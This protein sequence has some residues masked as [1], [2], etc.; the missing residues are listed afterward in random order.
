[1]T[2]LSPQQKS[3]N[4]DSIT[5]AMNILTIQ[6]Y[7]KM[8]KHEINYMVL[9][10]NGPIRHKRSFHK[11]RD[12]LLERKLITNR[13]QIRKTVRAGTK[14]RP[15]LTPHSFFKITVKGKKFLELV[16]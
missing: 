2:P 9:F 1:M 12:W 6:K 7:L 13:K 8:L 10:K 3:R 14:G 16:A 4:S 11:Y 5:G 15:F